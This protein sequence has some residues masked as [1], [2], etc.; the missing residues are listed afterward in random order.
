[1]VVEGNE[2]RLAA[3]PINTGGGDCGGQTALPE[4]YGRVQMDT[5]TV[6]GQVPGEGAHAD[7]PVC[8]KICLKGSSF[9][10]GV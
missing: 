9:E 7:W 8:L 1:M 10:F 5:E 6:V 3:T 2:G 4:Q